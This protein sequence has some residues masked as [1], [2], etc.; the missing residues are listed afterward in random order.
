MLASFLAISAVVLIEAAM[1]TNVSDML[2][3]NILLA[4]IIVCVPI[5]CFSQIYF[6]RIF[7]VK[8]ANQIDYVAIIVGS[9]SLFSVGSSLVSDYL[10]VA[11]SKM[12]SYNDTFQF[13]K[14]YSNDFVQIYC[15][16]AILDTHNSDQVKYCN[17]ANK[18]KQVGDTNNIDVFMKLIFYDKDVTANLNHDIVFNEDTVKN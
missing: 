7:D 2:K 5:F 10:S 14:K 1:A 3:L 12:T 15:Q 9:I 17:V 8:Y 13:F 6:A 4:L 18:F 16:A 11:S